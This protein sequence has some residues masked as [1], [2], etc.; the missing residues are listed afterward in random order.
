MSRIKGSSKTGG[1]VVGS[2]QTQTADVKRAILRVF[3][4]VNEDDE[5][6]NGIAHADKKL[7]LSL[8]ARILP[9]EVSVEQKVKFDLGAAMQTAADNS[10]R[11]A[12]AHAP[13]PVID[14]TPDTPDA[15]PV[16][17]K[18]LPPLI[19]ERVLPGEARAS[20]TEPEKWAG[21]DD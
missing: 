3:T 19:N 18:P 2:V 11:A 20:V 10:Q 8:V 4:A 6:L 15:A 17:V 9:A 12:L 16:E 13:A 7:F 21:Y 1:A 5:Y 14:M